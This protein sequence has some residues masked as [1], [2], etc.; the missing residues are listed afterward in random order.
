MDY[1]EVFQQ[2]MEK[3]SDMIGEVAYKQ[4]DQVKGV[5]INDRE[6]EG[7]IGEKQLKELIEKYHKIMGEG[8]YGVVR[9][10]IKEIYREDES[11]A[12]LELP[13]EVTPKEVR[14]SQFASA[15]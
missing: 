1:E 5:E 14:A 6:V 9:E 7:E 2:I 3:A 4:A 10:S 8:A 13:E 11:V 12:Q 15:L